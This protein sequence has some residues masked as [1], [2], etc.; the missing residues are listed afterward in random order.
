MSSKIAP[1]SSWRLSSDYGV[2][3]GFI[4]AGSELLVDDVYPPGT[5]GI[6]HIDEDTVVAH[7][8]RPDANPQTVAVAVSD[9]VSLCKAVS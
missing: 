4:P 3:P 7:Y 9:F 1:N 8:A 5:P 6:G 2:G